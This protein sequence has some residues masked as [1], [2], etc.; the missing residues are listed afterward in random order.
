MKLSL[1]KKIIFS[2]III[3]LFTILPLSVAHSATMTSGN[4]S[5]ER[6]SMNFGGSHTT[7]SSRI[8]E[9]TIGEVGAGDINSSNYKINAGYQQSNAVSSSGSGSDGSSPVSSS[10]GSHRSSVNVLNFQANPISESIN[11]TWQY[12][13][14]ASIDSVKIIR[15]TK[16][17]PTN[18]GDGEIIFEG[19]SNSVIDN[20]V[21]PG[22]TYYYAIFAKSA[23][24]VYS[25]G[26]LAQTILPK[27]GD[28]KSTIKSVE[29]LDRLPS[30]TN[31]DP[32]FKGLSFLDFNFIQDSILI[33]HAKDIVPIDG[34]KPLTISLDYKKVPET[35]KTIAISIS[36]SESSNKVFTFL[37]RVNK[38]KTAYEATIGSL[39]KN[40][41]YKI[42]AIVLDYK[43]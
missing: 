29:I 41:D 4:Y 34:N 32:A 25:S 30:A 35:L 40:G 13:F 20:N 6:D 33:N 3:L 36:D 9:D 15:S 28:I 22:I 43:N 24:G 16:F 1:N 42:N 38:D 17:F 12:P 2:Q 18:L 21:I 27:K 8:L 23:S 19:N 5:I 39:G 10:S 11:L 26:V 14:Q 37:L 7:G 31:V